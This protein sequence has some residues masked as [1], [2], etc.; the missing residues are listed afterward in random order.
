[1][2]ILTKGK[3]G[4]FGGQY[5]N[6]ILMPILI[7]LEEAFEKHYPTPEFQE[8]LNELLKDYAGRPTSLYYARN[9]SKLIGCKVYLKREDLVCGGSH[10]LN[11]AIGQALLTKQMGKT[12]MITET[13]AGQ[14]GLATAMAGNICGL[15]TEVFM[16]SKDIIRQAGNVKRI[17]LLGAKVTPVNIGMGVLKDAVSDTLRKWTACS[18]T[19]H[20]LMGSSVGPRPYPE[21]VATFQSVIGK[22]IKKQILQKEGKLPDTIVACGSG[23]SNALGAFRPFIQEKDVKLVFVE[24][25]G[26]TLD[27]DN[28]AAAF[29]IGKPGILHGAVMQV[30]QDE[31]GQIKPSRTRAAGLNYPGRGPEISGLVDS[32]RVKAGYAFDKQV[33]EAVKVMCRSEGLIPALETAHAI[34]YMVNNKDEFAKDEVIVLNFSGRGDKDLET[35]VRYFD[36]A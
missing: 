16:G 11:N 27:A 4:K 24:G 31:N 18:T 12:R 28:S 36:E 30:L 29:K 19:T 35:I 3:F 17:K 34:A 14:H 20:Y 25:G 15:E 33:F 8:K 21:I 7:E 9:F 23:G 5:V 1:V 2:K 6:E 22:E 26:E 13:A 32:G 10:K